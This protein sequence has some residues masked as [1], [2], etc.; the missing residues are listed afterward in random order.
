[1]DGRVVGWLGG[2]VG[3]GGWGFWRQ[4]EK[5]LAARRHG[6]C[7]ACTPQPMKWEKAVGMQQMH[8]IT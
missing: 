5:G 7:N 6:G 3:M 8:A 4:A 1:M 2:W